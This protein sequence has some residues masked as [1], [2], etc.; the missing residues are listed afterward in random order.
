MHQQSSP[1]SCQ[2]YEVKDTGTLVLLSIQVLCRLT[3]S[4]V[5]S[6]F[7]ND[8]SRAVGEEYLKFFDF[9]GQTL[10]HALR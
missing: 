1:K 4:V 9:T 5:F 8:F 3:P 6:L 2:A 10:D 7:S